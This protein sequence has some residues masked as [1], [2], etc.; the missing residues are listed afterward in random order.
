MKIHLRVTQF[1]TENDNAL[2]ADR[3]RGTPLCSCSSS[4]DT[5]RPHSS[6][7][8]VPGKKAARALLLEGKK[9]KKKEERKGEF[10]GK[11]GRNVVKPASSKRARVRRRDSIHALKRVLTKSCRMLRRLQLFSASRY[12]I[13]NHITLF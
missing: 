12:S 4:S 7:R 6:V 11:R 5:S 10:T 3:N 8:Y 9:K 13:F 2:S 1:K